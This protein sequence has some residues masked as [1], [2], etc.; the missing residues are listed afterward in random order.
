MAENKYTCVICGKTPDE[1]ME[2]NMLAEEEGY[3]NPTAAMMANEGTVNDA[4]KLFCC[5]DCYVKI[6]MPRGKAMPG[7]KV[8]G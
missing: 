2:Y 8:L 4:L 3:D 1:L 7:W 6:G 5:T